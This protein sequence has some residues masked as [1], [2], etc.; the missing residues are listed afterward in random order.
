M[1]QGVMSCPEAKEKQRALTEPLPSVPDTHFLSVSGNVNERPWA[2]H[3][4]CSE[5]SMPCKR[6]SFN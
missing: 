6:V 1:V 2:T 3:R 5:H 4:A